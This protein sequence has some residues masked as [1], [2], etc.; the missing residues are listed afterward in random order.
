MV[1]FLKDL[2]AFNIF[3][4]KRDILWTKLLAADVVCSFL[5]LISIEFNNLKN[6]T[7]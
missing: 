3:A 4:F 1:T 5:F 6:K 7:S 2:V